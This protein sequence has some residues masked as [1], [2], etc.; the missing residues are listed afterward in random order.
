[1]GSKIGSENGR[2]DENPLHTVF[3]DAY[4]ID[5][6]EVTN[7]MFQAFIDDTGYKTDAEK[8]SYSWIFNKKTDMG[9]E[10]IDGADW[11]HPIGP[12]SSLEGL[13]A[14][15]VVQISWNDA[16]AYCK[17]AGRELP[18]EAQWEKAVRGPDERIYPWGNEFD[19]NNGNFNYY[20]EPL[21][22][23][24]VVKGG[25]ECDKY[26]TTAPVGSFPEGASPYGAYD[27]SGN[28]KEWVADWYDKNFYAI[29]SA[30]DD[31]PENTVDS[32]NKVLRGHSWYFNEYYVR[33]A[34]R[35]YYPPNNSYQF[36][37]FRCASSDHTA[38]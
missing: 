31:N 20:D 21:V 8:R 15:P 22:D 4:W 2:E 6:T 32:E 5:Q 34:I 36:I 26:D 30:S 17:W 19:C 14:H 7:G 9:W 23:F 35:D 10:I 28:V 33:S 25:P 16:A 24:S 12:E 1:M 38:P 18:T 11:K 27:M 3:L 13:E 37:G 29:S